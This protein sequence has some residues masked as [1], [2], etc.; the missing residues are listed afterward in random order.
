MSQGRVVAKLGD[1]LVR[2][3]AEFDNEDVARVF[4]KTARRGN[5]VI[6]GV[7]DEALA[8]R[9]SEMARAA[10]DHVSSFI[11]TDAE[12]TIV[13]TFIS[14]DAMDEPEFTPQKDFQAHSVLHS[15]AKKGAKR[16]VAPT[17]RGEV[18]N[19]AYGGVVSGVPGRVFGKVRE[20][21]MYSAL[22]EGYTHL[23]VVD[24]NPKTVRF[25][26]A[27]PAQWR[28]NVPFTDVVLADQSR[29]LAGL[30]P[31]RAI[32]SISPLPWML[33]H[34][35]PLPKLVTQRLGLAATSLAKRSIAIFM[36]EKDM[37]AK[38]K[39]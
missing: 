29:P 19:G 27:L 1:Y 28:W 18:L 12:G 16:S 2:P 37:W 34:L 38:S 4:V 8:L 9:G 17:K 14:W 7:S 32:A 11:I 13:G 22:M 35:S 5:P 36:Q 3:M 10:K 21:A 30:S 24:V 15:M 6:G 31:N 25:A 23:Y 26:E 33:R 39:L 20:I